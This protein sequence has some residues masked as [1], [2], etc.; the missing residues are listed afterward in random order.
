MAGTYD[1]IQVAIDVESTDANNYTVAGKSVSGILVFNANGTGTFN[2]TEYR[3]QVGFNPIQQ[4]VRNASDS[5]STSVTSTGI[6]LMNTTES[7]SGTLSWT[8]S[9]GVVTV[10]TF[11]GTVLTY[12][13]AGSK[14]LIDGINNDEGQNGLNILVRR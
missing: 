9:N 7:D 11:D 12:I 3:R 2:I 10:T 1:L 13:V 8:L 14:I 6:Q 5:G 4:S